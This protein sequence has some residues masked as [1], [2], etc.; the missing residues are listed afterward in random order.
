[1]KPEN[2]FVKKAETYI[3]KIGD[4]G[5]SKKIEYEEKTL[6]IKRCNSLVGT[7]NYMAPEMTSKNYTD[8]IDVWSF[9][10]ILFELIKKSLLFPCF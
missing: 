9:G 7:V 4:F 2:I 3:F 5:L 10:C 8:K 6:K 1:M